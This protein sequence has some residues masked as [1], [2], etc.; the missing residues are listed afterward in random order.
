MAAVHASEPGSIEMYQSSNETCDR[1]R[2]RPIIL[3]RLGDCVV[4]PK[5]IEIFLCKGHQNSRQE[6]SFVV[7]RGTHARIRLSFLAWNPTETHRLS[8]CRTH[9]NNSR[10]LL[11]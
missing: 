9:F 6:Y 8:N 11:V 1:R 5:E 10:L 7:C 2:T 3:F 4:L